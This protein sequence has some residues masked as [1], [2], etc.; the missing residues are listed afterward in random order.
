MSSTL[1]ETVSINYEDFTD[2]FLTCG[3]CLCSYDG[4]EHTPKLLPCSHSVCRSCLER[5]VEA[6]GR[7]SATFRCPICRETITVPRGGPTAF[8]PSFLVNQLIDLINQVQQTTGKPVGFKTVVGAYGWLEKMCEEIN[9]RGPEF[10]PDFITIDS[11][12]GG[13]GAA[14]MPLMDNVGLPLRESLPMVVD[15]LCRY[16]L[17]ERIRIIA[18]GKLVTPAEIA[19]AY[20][21]GADF[22]ISARGFMFS[23]GCIQAMECNK[24][25]C[26]TGITTHDR[27]LQK[28]LNPEDKAIRVRNFVDKVRYGVGVIAHSC[29]V[30]HPRALKR[31]HVRI[32]QTN[33]KSVPLDELY[34]P[35]TAQQANF[36]AA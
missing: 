28:G 9:R 31:F 11:G 23:L 35:Q 34:P 15:I 16:G 19:W 3:T 32:V 10:A 21:V 20:C 14:P 2:S 7:D 4:L 27:R 6:S 30:P 36:E 1:V 22:A 12:D 5:I 29:G 18:S 8:P 17:R 13:T 24:N 33:G 25:T 26:P